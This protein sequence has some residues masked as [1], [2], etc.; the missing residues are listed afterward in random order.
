MSDKITDRDMP[1]LTEHGEFFETLRIG[2]CLYGK[3]KKLIAVA[4][5][6]NLTVGFEVFH[7]YETVNKTYSLEE[8]VKTYNALL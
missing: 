3:S 8:A 4:Y 5:Y 6:T 2:K 1:I 7:G